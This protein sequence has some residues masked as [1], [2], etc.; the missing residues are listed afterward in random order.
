MAIKVFANASEL[1][2]R[3]YY[4][5]WNQVTVSQ[6]I[7]KIKW[8]IKDYYLSYYHVMNSNV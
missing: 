5:R 6:Y 4:R 1:L 2:Q 7:F 3:S 8:N